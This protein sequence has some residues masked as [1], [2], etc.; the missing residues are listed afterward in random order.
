MPNNHITTKLCC[1]PWSDTKKLLVLLLSVDVVFI[2]LQIPYHMGMMSSPMFS[3]ETDRGYPE[4]YQYIKEFWII[5]L[6]FGAFL[7]H[8]PRLV[9]LVWTCLFAY[10]LVD[11]AM[12]VHENVGR[13][14]AAEFNLQPMFGLRA[15]DLGELGF[16]AIAGSL[17]FSGIGMAYFFSNAQGR[18]ITKHLTGL[19]ALLVM[20]GI[21]VD[22]IHEMVSQGKIVWGVIE[23]GGEMCIIS[24]MAWYVFKLPPRK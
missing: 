7:C 9:Y 18:T 12:S 21:G 17:L 19:F 5:L 3:I 22:M 6:L 1:E 23:D 10:I 20:F 24:L 14:A 2:L 11:D 15:R 16:S 13:W 8:K 4:V